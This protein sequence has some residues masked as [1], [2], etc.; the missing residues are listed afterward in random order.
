M[1][2]H[3]GDSHALLPAFLDELARDGRNVDFAMVDGD[4]SADGVRQD[5]E[6]LLA[7]DAL[8]R[9]VILIH[10]TCND[11][12]RRGL[13]AGQLES[14][15][16]VRYVDLDFI[17]GHLSHGDPYHHQLWGGLGVALVNADEDGDEGVPAPYGFYDMFDLLGAAREAVVARED[18]G[19]P[20]PA[21]DASPRRAQAAGG[22][23][24]EAKGLVD[25][26]ASALGAGFEDVIAAE[27][28][29]VAQ[30]VY[31]VG[32]ML[33]P[34][35]ARPAALVHP[36]R[37]PVRRRRGRRRLFPRRLDAG[38]GE[39]HPGGRARRATV[40][41]TC[42]TCSGSGPR[43]IAPGCPRASPSRWE[44]RRWTCSTTT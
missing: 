10:D 21:R 44:G 17:A 15:P 37:Q 33:E 22:E 9:S 5:M 18:G 19:A 20:P 34:R 39:R 2:L 35:R 30:E 40:S 7:S 31:A 36:R 8:R 27:R 42:T 28:P 43:A 6:H 41:S 1:E 13:L 23:R 16:K 25:D 32:S 38:I 11:E 12:V 4:H 26:S 24:P 14:V 3:I 29:L